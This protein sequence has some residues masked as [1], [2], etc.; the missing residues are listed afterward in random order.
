MIS[1]LATVPFTLG[2][3]C[4]ILRVTL[5][6][7]V[8]DIP[9]NPQLELFIKNPHHLAQEILT[10]VMIGD[11]TVDDILDTTDIVGI[12]QTYVLLITQLDVDFTEGENLR[13]MRVG[14]LIGKTDRM[15]ERF[16]NEL[17]D[18]RK[19]CPNDVVVANTI[20]TL[21]PL[22]SGNKI[23]NILLTILLGALL[24][25]FKYN[26]HRNKIAS[27]V[28]GN[29]TYEFIKYDESRTPR[30]LFRIPE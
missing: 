12:I 5:N 2:Q 22:R 24:D 9:I 20:N 27:Y 13:M 18:I 4:G 7:D 21:E 11:A 17:H 15:I 30:L 6:T 19:L 23:D 8:F 16:F 26:L 14:S 25:I 29:Q 10:G 1:N 3:V 28:S